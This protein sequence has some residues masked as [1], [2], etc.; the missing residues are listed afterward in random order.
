M[1]KSSDD[2]DDDVDNSP[3]G[4]REALVREMR[5][6]GARA[7]YQALLDVCQDKKAPAPAR[8]TAGT[9]ILRASGFFKRADDDDHEKPIH[10]MSVAEMDR[11]IQAL[12]R[13]RQ[14]RA[15]AQHSEVFE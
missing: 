3:D 9:S 10:E 12:D 4:I 5:T 15:T 2:M 8:A 1:T 7:A 14:R 13:K 6:V 11:K